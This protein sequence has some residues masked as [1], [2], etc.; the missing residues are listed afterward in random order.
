MSVEGRRMDAV[1]YR[2]K[3]RELREK[4]RTTHAQKV[5]AHLLMIA[6]QYDRLGAGAEDQQLESEK[7]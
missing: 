5:R 4:A 2:A 7:P 6:D 3:A 1:D